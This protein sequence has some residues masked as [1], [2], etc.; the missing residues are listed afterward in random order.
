VE[1]AVTKFAAAALVARRQ[2]KLAVRQR[3]KRVGVD[4]MI[5]EWV[6]RR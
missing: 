2:M 1:V 4:L 5:L 3:W 6:V